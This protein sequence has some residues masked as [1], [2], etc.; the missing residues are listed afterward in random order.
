[1]LPEPLRQRYANA[2]RGR[3]ALDTAAVFTHRGEQWLDRVR[4]GASV[5]YDISYDPARG[6]WYLDASWSTVTKGQ[7]VF[8]PALEVLR[9]RP[10]LAVDV[11]ADHLAAWIL[12]PCGNPVDGPHTIPLDLAG[13][14][15]SVRDARLREAI[16]RLIHLAQVHGCAALVIEDLDFVDARATG[17][18]TMGRGTRGKA[19][20]RTVS[21]IPTGKFRD[22]VTGMAHHTGLSVIAVDPAYSSKWGAQHWLGALK[23]TRTGSTIVTGH[24]AASVV[25]GRRGLGV[26]ARRRRDGTRQ[27]SNRHMLSRVRAGAVRPED[28]TGPAVPVS[29]SHRT[30]ARAERTAPAGT[31]RS[32]T[33][34]VRQTRSR[35]PGKHPPHGPTTVRGPSNPDQQLTLPGMPDIANHG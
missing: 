31:T 7:K 30:Q 16:S 28:R 26:K 5:R 10:A 21:G 4:A 13:L 8:V 32:T 25:V 18:E 35:R 34:V 9:Q 12:D 27:T 33:P 1:M 17:R 3:Y 22:R 20:R 2:P 29:P 6:R 19:F 11:N 24:H 14:P 23:E 15:A